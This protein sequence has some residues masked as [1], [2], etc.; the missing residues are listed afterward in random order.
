MGPL[1]ALNEAAQALAAKVPDSPQAQIT[2]PLVT[3]RQCSASS[4]YVGL[5]PAM[6][7]CPN[8]RGATSHHDGRLV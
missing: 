7:S 1:R 5:A 2:M 4:D 8:S 6:Q 3:G